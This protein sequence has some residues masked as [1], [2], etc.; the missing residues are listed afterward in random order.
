[1]TSRIPPLNKYLEKYLESIE[2]ANEPLKGEKYKAYRMDGRRKNGKKYDDMRED[3][4]LG[5]CHCCDYFK[6]QGDCI[7]LIEETQL[8]L[9]IE[10]YKEEYDAMIKEDK[11]N[12]FIR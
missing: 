4:G 8:R 7:V 12:K 2:V 9:T 3:V 10:K 11:K 1:M 6:I 5:T